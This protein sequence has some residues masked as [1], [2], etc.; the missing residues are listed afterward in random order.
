MVA[1][2]SGGELAEGGVECLERV[3]DVDQAADIGF[4]QQQGHSG[5]Y[6][7]IALIDA[8]L[9]RLINQ[10][11]V[12]HLATSDRSRPALVPIC[13]VLL[14]STVY[15]AIDAK[16]K[17][18]SPTSL[19]RVQNVLANPKAVVLVDHYEEDWQ[20]LWWVTLSGEAR[21]LT[22]G[23]EQA[24]AV[25]ALRKKYPQYRRGWPLR[26]GAPVIALNVGRLHYWQSS[27]GGRGR[28]VRPDPAA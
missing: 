25:I 28:A 5:D 14:R 3:V 12:A 13:F 11:R 6:V 4:A 20:M 8:S 26:G 27:S 9:R 24:R 1:G 7:D 10:A 19:R 21:V 18:G 23:A 2:L 22:D 15:H 16:P 17:R